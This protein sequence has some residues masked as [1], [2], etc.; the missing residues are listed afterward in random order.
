MK[1]RT[2]ALLIHDNPDSLT[3][4]KQA[5]RKL[6]VETFSVRNCREAEILLPQ[7][8][9]Q[10]VFVDTTLSEGSWVDAIHLAEKADVPPN[11]IVVGSTTNIDLYLS[12]MER[13]AFDFVAPPYE[14]DPLEYVVQSAALDARTRKQA[15]AQAAVA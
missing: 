6:A 1:D 11:V 15:L 8:Q 3:G 4:L 2:F 5:L 14:L 7:T 10:V 9:P 12:A 13:G